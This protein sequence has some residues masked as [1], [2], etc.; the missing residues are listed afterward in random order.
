[1][2]VNE[3]VCSLT[4]P[5]TMQSTFLFRFLSLISSRIHANAIKLP[6]SPS[7]KRERDA[8]GAAL[9]LI[10]RWITCPAGGKKEKLSTKEV[11]WS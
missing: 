5:I 8:R 7:H 9:S 11:Q 2:T 4:L 1:M 10:H 6:S 3:M